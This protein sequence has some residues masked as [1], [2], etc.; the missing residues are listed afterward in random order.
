MPLYEYMCEAEHAFEIMCKFED[1]PESL[2]CRQCDRRAELQ[3][4]RIGHAKMTY[5]A[6]YGYA[7]D[8]DRRDWMKKLDV[9][10]WTGP[11]T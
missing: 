9:R 7:T 6:A 1:R 8:S 4:S 2:P 5:G 10:G 11:G 3:V